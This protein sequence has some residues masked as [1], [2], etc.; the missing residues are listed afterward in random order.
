[1]MRRRGRG[2]RADAAD[3]AFAKTEMDKLKL[4]GLDTIRITQT[5][6]KG[7]TALGPNDAITLGNAIAAPRSSPACASSSRS[8]RSVRA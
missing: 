6:T 2:R 3:S 1:M 4:A 7:Q 5:W 8:I